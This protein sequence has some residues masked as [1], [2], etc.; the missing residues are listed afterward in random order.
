[1]F[2]ARRALLT[3][4]K[5]VS[6]KQFRFKLC[7]T[8]FIL[9]CDDGSVSYWRCQIVNF[10]REQDVFKKFC[11]VGFSTKRDIS[12]RVPLW[13]LSI[14]RH[15]AILIPQNFLSYPTKISGMKKYSLWTKIFPLA[16]EILRLPALILS[17]WGSEPAFFWFLLWIETRTLLK[18]DMNATG[19]HV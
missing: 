11:C 5:S 14:K 7:E 10:A 13:R 6:Y 9:C 17:S 8:V 16:K 2:Y 19:K 1:M 3:A 18:L 15:P 4:L 12:N